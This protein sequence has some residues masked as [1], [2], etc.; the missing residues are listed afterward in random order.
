MKIY[1]M[2]LVF[3]VTALLLFSGCDFFKPKETPPAA[4]PIPPPD[5]V[6][7]PP[8][9]PPE[10]IPVVPPPNETVVAPPENP[11]E[12][13]NTADSKLSLDGD[14]SL[15]DLFGFDKAK[16]AVFRKVTYEKGYPDLTEITMDISDDSFQGASSWKVITTHVENGSDVTETMWL[17]KESLVCIGFEKGTSSVASCPALGPFGTNRTSRNVQ[18][19]GNQNIIVSLGTF[20]NTP[21]YEG[22]SITY[23]K[24]SDKPFPLK[25]VINNGNNVLATYELVGSS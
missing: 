6:P 16:K 7:E 2:L 3:A 21:K 13:V 20:D 12:V 14:T 22:D 15:K 19:L 24:V 10:A 1:P 9:A 18:L 11:V 4:E 5:V 8:Q 25:Y 17:S 23:W